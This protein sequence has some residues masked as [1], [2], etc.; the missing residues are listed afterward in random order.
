MPPPGHSGGR[1]RCSETA[2]DAATG[3]VLWSYATGGIINTAP[4]ISSGMLY[5]GSFDDNLYAFGLP[6]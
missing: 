6:G 4:A 5:V 3:A 2:F 1:A